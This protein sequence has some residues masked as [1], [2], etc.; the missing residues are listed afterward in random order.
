MDAA[1]AGLL[2]SFLYDVPTTQSAFEHF[3][4]VLAS[5]G[6]LG[7]SAAAQTY[8]L[9]CASSSDPGMRENWL[10]YAERRALLE[11][12]GFWD[13]AFWTD[14]KTT[15]KPCFTMDL[16]S[17][18][19]DLAPSR[20]LQGQQSLVAWPIEFTKGNTK[21]GNRPG[22]V[23][24]AQA[25]TLPAAKRTQLLLDETADPTDTYFYVPSIRV[26]LVSL[27]GIRLRA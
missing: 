24:I 25:S 8:L 14:P 7:T 12:S 15:L 26:D 9:Q 17:S 23:L 18:L 11:M 6:D 16:S 5:V 27:Y 21:I 19:R 1:V 20:R 10:R 4:T 3:S 22:T 13:P 2:G